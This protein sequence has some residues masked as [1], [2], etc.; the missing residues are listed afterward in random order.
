MDAD[1]V[2]VV[3]S[4]PPLRTVLTVRGLLGLTGY[5]RRFTAAMAALRRH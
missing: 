5:Y 2:E 1:K 4:W 3:K